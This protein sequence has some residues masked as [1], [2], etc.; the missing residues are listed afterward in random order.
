M[1]K[2]TNSYEKYFENN[3]DIILN[4]TI[5]TIITSNTYLQNFKKLVYYSLPSEINARVHESYYHLLKYKNES[6]ESLALRV[7]ETKMYKESEL[8]ANFDYKT[9]INNSTQEELINFINTFNSYVKENIYFN[10]QKTNL[11][12]PGDIEK[13]FKKWSEIFYKK[14]TNM[15]YKL[16]NIIRE[17]KRNN[18]DVLDEGLFYIDSDFFD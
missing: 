8:L 10:K 5:R 13:F 18:P 12:Y 7:R 9:L 1:S 15:Q 16:S 2:Q 4:P 14:G 11:Q 3:Q 17:I 6:I